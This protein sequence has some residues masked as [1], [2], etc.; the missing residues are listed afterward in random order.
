MPSGRTWIVVTAIAAALAGGGGALLFLRG[1][2]G[3]RPGTYRG[4]RT[5]AFYAPIGTRALDPRPLTQ[6]EVFGPG[7]ASLA[8]AGVTLVRRSV[9]VV[10][11]CAA[12]VWGSGPRAA[13]AG[14][15]Q[16]LR[17]VYVSAAGDVSG[18]FQIFNLPDGKAAD[19]LVTA[20]NHKG[21]GFVR[22]GPGQPGSFDAARSR[23]QVRALGHYVTVSWV[24]PAGD[25]RADLTGA[26]IALDG[27]GRVVQGRV[28]GAG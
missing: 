19:T 27:L 1:H 5:S 16:A 12:A 2:D 23:A 15:S 21:D 22:L 11:D 25:E 4:E 18:Q 6:Q 13:V 9:T 10:S 14:C 7:T 24:G 17:A 26:Q 20:L 8:A 3:P 28:V